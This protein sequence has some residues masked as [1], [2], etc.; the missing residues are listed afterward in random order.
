MDHPLNTIL[1]GPPGTGKTYATFQRCVQICDLHRDGKTPKEIHERYHELLENRRV[2]FIT[3]H[4]SYGYEEFVEGLRPETEGDGGG[5]RLKVRD[6]VLKRIAERARST[7]APETGKRRFFKIVLG[8]GD[9][10]DECMT[11]G[12]VR[13]G[14]SKDW[15]DEDWSDARYG[16]Y[17]ACLNRFEERWGRGAK[18]WWNPTSAATFRASVN[19]G[20]IVVVPDGF[21]KSKYRAVGEIVGDYEYAERSSSPSWPH[22][23]AVRWDWQAGGNPSSVNDFQD[24]SF[25]GRRVHELRPVRPNILLQHLPHD[26][27]RPPYVLVIDEINRANIAKVL[28]ELITLLEEDKRDGAA[29]EMA[30]TLRTLTNASRCRRTSMCWGP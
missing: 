3:F 8:D 24:K 19:R 21:S 20:D 5:L 15:S 22:R 29:N 26:S 17:E 13:F 30:V 4:Q 7:P 28:G 6:G 23:R 1:Y 9:V 14:H 18:R 25:G 12:C 10:F 11:D 16:T 2:E 27:Q